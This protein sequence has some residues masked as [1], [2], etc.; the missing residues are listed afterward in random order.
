MSAVKQHKE[1][2]GVVGVGKNAVQG[3]R[4][5]WRHPGRLCVQLGPPLD[6]SSVPVAQ[7]PEWVASRGCCAQRVPSGVHRSH[8]QQRAAPQHHSTHCNGTRG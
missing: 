6:H 1:C 4:V 5:R 8:M 2:G 3:G 7:E